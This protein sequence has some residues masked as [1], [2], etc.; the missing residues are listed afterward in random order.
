MDSGLSFVLTLLGI[1]T[2]CWRERSANM[3]INTRDEATITFTEKKNEDETLS[4]SKTKTK[5]KGE[6]EY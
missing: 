3:R 1:R 5:H 4:P 2:L 6:D